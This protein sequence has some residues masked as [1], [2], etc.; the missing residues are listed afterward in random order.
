MRT[1]TMGKVVAAAVIGG[2][3]PGMAAAQQDGGWKFEAMPYVWGAGME[4]DVAIGRLEAGGI[5]MSFNDITE[6]LRAG[7]MGSF[8]GRKGNWGFFLD[9]IYMKLHQAHETP[10]LV[11]A[12]VDGKMTQQ[13]YALAG[14]WRASDAVDLVAGARTNYLKVDLDMSSSALAPQG[15]SLVKNRD[16]VDGYV[17]IRSRAPLGDRWAIAGYADVGAGGSDL[18]W[19]A[20]AS[21][22]YAMSRDVA[23]KVGYRYFK[24]EYDK[25][26]FKW[27]MATAGFFAGLAVKF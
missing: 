2:L 21:V 24:V 15:R 3:L 12:N 7:F 10:R 20:M 22:D 5:E 17:G 18:T 19:Q 11:V 1:K 27:D 13:A 14:M 16:W 25:S 9:A 26:D 6:S 23:M 8:E 4:G